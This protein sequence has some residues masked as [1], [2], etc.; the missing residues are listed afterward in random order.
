MSLSW[1]HWVVLGLVLGLAEVLGPGGFDF[2]FFS[3]G[4]VAVGVLSAVGVAG[5]AYA[6]LLEF[7]V[8]SLISL[9]LFR[10]RWL[11]R[12]ARD[13]HADQIDTLVSEV[14]TLSEDLAPGAVGKVELRGAAWTAKNVS[15]SALKRGARCVVV[16]VEGLTLHVGPE[17]ASG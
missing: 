3:V 8:L 13:P 12:L 1:W 16:H 5:P 11:G 14:G 17:G 15:P 7:S 4:A 6:Q 9:S 10:S 2:I